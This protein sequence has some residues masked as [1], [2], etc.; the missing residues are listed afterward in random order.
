MLKNKKLLLIA[1]MAC[2]FCSVGAQT[3]SPYSRYGYG[4][5]R[6]QVVGP[7]KGMGGIGYGLRN[8]LSANPSN[9]ASYSGVDSLTFLFDVGVFANKAKLSDNS[10]SRSDYNGGLDYITILMPV[11]KGIGV[12]AGIL[13]FSS[14]GY[15]FGASGTEGSVNYIRTFNGSGGF[16]QIYA[17]VGY[18]T[19]FVKGLS[20]G[21]NASFL[22]G[23]LS[24]TRSLSYL[25]TYGNLSTEISELT[26]KT[27]KFD[28]GAQYE[29]QLNKNNKLILGAVFSPSMN[30]TANF[31]NLHR[32][33]T[34]AGSTISIDTL[35]VNGVNAGMPSTVGLGFTLVHKNKLVVGADVLYQ[36]WTKVKYSSLMG[37]GLKASDRFNDRWKYSVGGEFTP[38]PLSRSF[39]Q[40]VKFRAGANYSNSYLNVMNSAGEINGFN[41]YGA[42]IGFGIPLRDRESFGSRT[43]YLNINLEYKKIKPE[44]SSMIDEQYFGISVNV[45]MNELWFFKKKVY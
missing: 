4:V 1:I 12:S 27:F 32:E 30:T 40:R 39:I 23:T 36:S 42:T 18:K 44:V 33:F 19:P 28:I 16:S 13:P 43:S 2:F 7:S 26:M 20:V 17:G 5:L 31:Q 45:N 15:D 25:S 22:F 41:E 24:H 29:T 6:D 9:P 37:D 14:V 21:A 10:G 3:N 11:G 8:S 35:A 34:A 38:D